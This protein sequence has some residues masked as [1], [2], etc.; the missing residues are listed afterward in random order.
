MDDLSGKIQSILSDPESMQQLQELA[1]M[2]SAGEGNQEAAAAPP[3]APGGMP[4]AAMLMKLG[5]MMQSAPHDKNADL[6]LALRP[7]LG[8]G[9]QQRVDKA[10]RLLRMWAVFRMLRESGA[11]QEFL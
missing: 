2:F 6:L 7:H 1:Q 4:D 5:Q 9:R 10:V 8:E 3:P 11:L